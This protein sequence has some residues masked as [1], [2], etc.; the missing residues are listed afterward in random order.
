MMAGVPKKSRVGKVTKVPPP[1]T[2]LMA[3]PAAAANTNPKISLRDI[4]KQYFDPFP[5]VTGVSADYIDSRRY[6]AYEPRRLRNHFRLPSAKVNRFA[7]PTELGRNRPR[8]GIPFR[9]RRSYDFVCDVLIHA[10]I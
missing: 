2:A 6:G 1:A 5:D 8:I 7:R 3:P 10:P 9:H 4:E